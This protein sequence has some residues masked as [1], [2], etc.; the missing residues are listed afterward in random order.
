L[1]IVREARQKSQKTR[2]VSENFGG[3]NCSR[4]WGCPEELGGGKLE[5]GDIADALIKQLREGGGAQEG[6][7]KT[8]GWKI[9]IEAKD[10]RSCQDD[11]KASLKM[12]EEV[13]K[14]TLKGT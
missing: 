12:A 14:G 1:G 3:G 11:R 2:W 9:R 4:V 7:A 5:D 10:K 8:G 6:E 13:S